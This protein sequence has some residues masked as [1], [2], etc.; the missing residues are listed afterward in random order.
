MES[1]TRLTRI[2]LRMA[3][4]EITLQRYWLQEW[5]VLVSSDGVTWAPRDGHG[6]HMTLWGKPLERISAHLWQTSDS[7]QMRLHLLD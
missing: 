1:E 6:Q 7:Q 5:R 4:D 2:Q 3:I